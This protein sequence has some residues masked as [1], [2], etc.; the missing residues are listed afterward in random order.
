VANKH[1]VFTVFIDIEKANDMVN[2]EVPLS[3]PLVNSHKAISIFRTNF[4]IF[5]MVKQHVIF[6]RK[7]HFFG[8]GVL[9]VNLTHNC[10]NRLFK[11]CC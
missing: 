2:V 3:K 7:C 11:Y 4:L 10:L 5:G 1:N 8:S 6:F 9:C